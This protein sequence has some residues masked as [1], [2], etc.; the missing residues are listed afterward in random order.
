MEWHV[1]GTAQDRTG[2]H[3]EGQVRFIMNVMFTCDSINYIYLRLALRFA[4][5]AKS[6]SGYMP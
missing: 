5:Q 2:Q 4:D 1:A 3:R 6:N